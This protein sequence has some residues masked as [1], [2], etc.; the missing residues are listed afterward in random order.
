MVVVRRTLALAVRGAGL[1]TLLCAVGAAAGGLGWPPTARASRRPG[2]NSPDL[3][4][5]IVA[6]LRALLR[7]VV[8]VGGAHPEV[9]GIVASALILRLL[10]GVARSRLAA[11]A[12]RDPRRAYTGE[13]RQ[14]GFRRAGHRCEFDAWLGLA[15]CRR[16]AEH[17][18][19]WWPHS[20]GGA[21]TMANLVAGCARHNVAKGAALPTAAQTRR[22]ARRRRRYFLPGDRAVPGERYRVR[23]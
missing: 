8:D 17:A 14:A 13:E 21:T 12:P 2:G 9:A 6:S 15:R 23:R 11:V 3:A 1:L 20:R 18:D 19:H 22:I 7:L 16:S 4:E 5:W 10:I